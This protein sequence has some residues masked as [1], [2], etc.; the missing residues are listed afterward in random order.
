MISQ[1]A[2]SYIGLIIAF[3]I[4]FFALSGLANFNDYKRFRWSV[5]GLIACWIGWLYYRL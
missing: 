3:G 1:F 5:I 2:N 4:L